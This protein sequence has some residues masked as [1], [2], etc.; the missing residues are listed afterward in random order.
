MLWIILG[1]A[2]L[3]GLS[4]S[5][6]CTDNVRR[7]CGTSPATA[8]MN[9][10][11]SIA[12]SSEFDDSFR[13]QIVDAHNQ[14]RREPFNGQDATNMLEIS[15]DD[16]LARTALNWA[17][18]LCIA[19]NVFGPG[20]DRCRVTPSYSSV[21]QNMAWGAGG[22]WGLSSVLANKTVD[23]WYSEHKLATSADLFPFGA[24]MAIGHYTQLIW[25][26]SHKIGCAY[27]VR[28][29]PYGKQSWIIC[30]YAKSGNRVGQDVFERGTQ[31]SNCPSGSTRDSTGLCRVSNDAQ[32]RSALGIQEP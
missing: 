28:T 19:D 1:A 30:N 21:G 13:R 16:E 9:D 8:C 27:I 12:E 31:G 25:A 7:F 5:Q 17:H 18:Q 23:M 10:R 2:A 24:K 26:R 11:C 29:H 15:W 4:T 32:L 22:S 3:A 6:L 14:Y 20:H